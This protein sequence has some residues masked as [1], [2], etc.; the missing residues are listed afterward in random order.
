MQT[1]WNWI[2]DFL[3][4]KNL[5]AFLSVI[6]AAGTAIYG[7]MHPDKVQQIV[8][9]IHDRLG[10]GDKPPPSTSTS[11]TGTMPR[12]APPPSGDVLPLLP[13]TSNASDFGITMDRAAQVIVDPSNKRKIHLLMRI[14]STQ[15]SFKVFALNNNMATLGWGVSSMNSLSC[16]VASDLQGLSNYYLETKVGDMQGLQIVGPGKSAILNIAADCTDSVSNNDA[17]FVN[18]RLYALADNASDNDKSFSASFSAGPISA[19]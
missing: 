14:N 6:V 15:H 9:N 1:V 2:S 18:A 16:H 5:I 19:K 11:A 3:K 7:I 4:P 12:Q 8:I 13:M 10:M 17:F